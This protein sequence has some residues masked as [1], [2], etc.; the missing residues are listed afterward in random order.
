MDA[1]FA[2]GLP[3]LGVAD[4]RKLAGVCKVF[5]RDVRGETLE[6]FEPSTD[7]LEGGNQAMMV[8]EGMHTAV[9]KWLQAK[10][11]DAGKVKEMADDPNKVDTLR[12]VASCYRLLYYICWDHPENWVHFSTAPP[13]YELLPPCRLSHYSPALYRCTSARRRSS[14]SSSL[15]S[16]NSPRSSSTASG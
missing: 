9:L 2:N 7:N 15:N 12:L 6:E 3:G 4:I 5:K 16:T 1:L 10:K 8:A 11:L 13:T 14:A